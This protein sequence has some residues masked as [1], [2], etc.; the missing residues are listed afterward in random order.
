MCLVMGSCPR[1]IKGVIV[2][3]YSKSCITFLN[4]ENIET[5]LA[6]WTSGRGL[7]TQSRLPTSCPANKPFYFLLS[8]LSWWPLYLWLFSVLAFSF[9]RITSSS[10]FPGPDYPSDSLLTPPLSVPFNSGTPHHCQGYCSDLS[11][12]VPFPSWPVLGTD[13]RGSFK[14]F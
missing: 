13:A 11:V 9:L 4:S 1:P 12:A 6:P 5:Y 2:H 10:S 14:K 7:Q 8:S 3:I